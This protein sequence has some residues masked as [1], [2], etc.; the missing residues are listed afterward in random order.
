[1]P[2]GDV[3]VLDKGPQPVDHLGPLD[4]PEVC[5]QGEPDREQPLDDRVMQI[6]GDSFAVFEQRQVCDA[7]VQPGVLDRDA[8]GRGERH[9]HL[10]VD[11]G[12]HVVAVLVAQVQVPEHLAPHEDGSTEER[13]HRRVVGGKP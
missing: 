1:M 6:T 12:E 3:E 2:D 7:C 4:Q 5:L 9:H 11:V 13:A 8:C 10:L